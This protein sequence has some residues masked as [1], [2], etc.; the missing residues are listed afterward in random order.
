MPDNKAMNSTNLTTPD[1]SGRLLSLNSPNL[2]MAGSSG[3][4]EECCPPVVDPYTFLALIGGIAL[5]TYFLQQ[6]IV[7]TT[8]RVQQYCLHEC[9]PGMAF[10]CLLLIS[11]KFSFQFEK[12]RKRR[13]AEDI[14]NDL[15]QI[16]LKSEYGAHF[17]VEKLVHFYVRFG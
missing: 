15:Q 16:V 12:R 8:V 3:Y 2:V 5:A 13:G 6:L 10:P 17:G 1:Q 4:G 7:G 11:I 14:P 9:M